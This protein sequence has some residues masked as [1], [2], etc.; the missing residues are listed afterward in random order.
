MCG[1]GVDTAGE[2]AEED[3][4]ARA[5]FHVGVGVD[6]DFE[7]FIRLRAEA[8]LMTDA[9]LE[10]GAALGIEPAEGVEDGGGDEVVPRGHA[11]VAVEEKED[12]KDHCHEEVGGFEEF[13]IAVAVQR[14]QVSCQIKRLD[15]IKVIE[16]LTE[17][18]EWT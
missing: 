9:M 12:D 5:P 2:E 7:H 18:M 10:V 16:W 13:V 8:G 6:G 11:E 3:V 17:S 1:E 4:L 15:M 14:D